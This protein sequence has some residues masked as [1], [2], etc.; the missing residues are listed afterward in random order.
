M[1][2]VVGEEV[3]WLPVASLSDVPESLLGGVH[4][5]LRGRQ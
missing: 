4:Y 5:S 2:S 1:G 3:G